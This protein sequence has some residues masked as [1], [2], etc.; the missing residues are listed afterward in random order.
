MCV[1]GPTPR[2]QR[3]GCV[4]GGSCSSLIGRF[5]DPCCDTHNKK[6]PVIQVRV[7]YSLCLGREEAVRATN[8]DQLS[9]DTRY[10]C[11]PNLDK[12][13]FSHTKDPCQSLAQ[14]FCDHGEDW[15]W[16][17]SSRTGRSL[18]PFPEVLRNPAHINDNHPSL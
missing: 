12:N 10:F 11:N 6:S 7:P 1:P 13:P 14:I 8:R 17:N 4:V 2:N 5:A 9:Y 15:I 16:V 18:H 3:K